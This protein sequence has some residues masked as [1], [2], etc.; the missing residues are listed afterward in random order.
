MDRFQKKNLI[1]VTE[2]SLHRRQSELTL[3]HRVSYETRVIKKVSSATLPSG[4]TEIKVYKAN[5]RQNKS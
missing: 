4:T 2:L 5:Q 3:E 1:V